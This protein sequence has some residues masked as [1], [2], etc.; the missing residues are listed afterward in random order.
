MLFF[1]V[2]LIP[3]TLSSSTK[4]TRVLLP[5]PSRR[6]DLFT[7]VFRSIFMVPSRA[8]SASSMRRTSLLKS[9]LPQSYVSCSFVL[10]MVRVA[11]WSK[12]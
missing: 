3:C 4:S 9:A 10:S 8:P 2:S 5:D 12:T 1:I 11:T 7:S 6:N